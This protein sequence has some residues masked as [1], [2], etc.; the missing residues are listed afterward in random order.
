MRTIKAQM[1][2]PMLSL[3]YQFNEDSPAP[4]QG[5]AQ[6]VEKVLVNLY[7]QI[8][9]IQHTITEHYGEAASKT[10][11]YKSLAEIQSR[12]G[13][14]ATGVVKFIQSRAKEEE[15]EST[16]SVLRRKK[17]AQTSRKQKNAQTSRA[18]LL[19]SQISSAGESEEKEPEEKKSEEKKSEETKS[20]EKKTEEKK[21]LFKV[22][23]WIS[24][25]EKESEENEKNE[26]SS[27]E[28][29]DNK[30]VAELEEDMSTSNQSP[31]ILQPLEERHK[32][33]IHRTHALRKQLERKKQLL[34]AAE[35]RHQRLQAEINE[36]A[37][38]AQHDESS[39]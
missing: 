26:K 18:Q 13:T 38:N 24:L 20:E 8:D 2:Y 30:K 25:G 5:D 22:R 39:S 33:A 11:K 6:E 32:V 17:K 9:V 29:H 12:L 7:G 16:S 34:R 31:A 19:E 10:E 23:E 21:L 36:Q 27:T 1:T 15:E 4:Y 35:D 3:T 28:L 14:L 37:T